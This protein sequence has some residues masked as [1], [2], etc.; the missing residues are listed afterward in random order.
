MKSAWLMLLIPCLFDIALLPGDYPTQLRYFT[1][2]AIIAPPLGPLVKGKSSIKEGFERNV[3]DGVVVLSF[4][5]T[6]EDFWTCGRHV[7]E[8]GSWAMAQRSSRTDKPRAYYGSYFQI[9]RT[10]PDS[11]L[12]IEYCIYTLGFNPWE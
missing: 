3:R 12:L 11:S 1:D 10:Q 6:M 2:D 9:W 4:N 7:Y 8:R 5:A